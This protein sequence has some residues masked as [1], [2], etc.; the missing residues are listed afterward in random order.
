M[1]S[2]K[3]KRDKASSSTRASHSGIFPIG[4]QVCKK[5]NDGWYTGTVISHDIILTEAIDSLDGSNGGGA[6]L[7]YLIRY[8]DDDLEHLSHEE[9]RRILPTKRTLSLAAARLQKDYN[10][11][12]RTDSGMGIAGFL[13]LS[14]ADRFEYSVGQDACVDSEEKSRA[15]SENNDTTET[16]PKF[17]IGQEVCREFTTGWYSGNVRNYRLDEDGQFIYLIEYE[18]GDREELDQLQVEENLPTELTLTLA[19]S[20]RWKEARKQELSIQYPEKK[21]RSDL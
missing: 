21:M 1:G 14:P 4:Q 3:R 8:E 2:S 10:E 20:R 7:K 5:F 6:P 9:V 12:E 17:Q 11:H 13:A 19:A 15:D 18:D 16:E